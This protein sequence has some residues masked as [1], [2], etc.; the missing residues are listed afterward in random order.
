MGF[1]S[2][3]RELFDAE[4]PSKKTAAIECRL[5]RELAS[6]SLVDSSSILTT[7]GPLRTDRPYRL[8]GDAGTQQTILI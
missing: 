7:G 3:G 8:S 6:R 1:Q 2:K 5:D 4:G